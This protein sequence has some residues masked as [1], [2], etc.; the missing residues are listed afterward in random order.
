MGHLAPQL[1]E[2]R[3]NGNVQGQERHT[4]QAAQDCEGRDQPRQKEV[5]GVRY[6]RRQGEARDLWRP[7]H[8]NQEK[9]KGPTI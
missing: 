5:C 8:E 6:G 4:E 9:P 2:R 1:W 3:D 7:Q